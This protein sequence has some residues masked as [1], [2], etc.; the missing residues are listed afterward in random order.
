MLLGHDIAELLL[1]HVTDHGLGLCAQHVQRIDADFLVGRRLQGQQPHLGAVAVSH[2]D[3]MVDGDLLDPLS[4][5]PHIGALILCRHGLTTSQQSI[6]AQ[7]NQDSHGFFLPS[8]RQAREAT[9]TALMVCMRFS[10]WSK[11]MHAGDSKTDSVTSMP[12]ASCG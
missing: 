1:D 6:A 10:A 4:R 12:L 5:N 3:L 11:A 9:M 2:D 8:H 7:C